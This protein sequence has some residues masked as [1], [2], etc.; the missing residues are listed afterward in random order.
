METTSIRRRALP[1]VLSLVGFY[2]LAFGISAALLGL[3]IAFMHV[4]FLVIP[5]VTMGLFVAIVVV[6]AT[7]QISVD[8]E[9]PPEAVEVGEA[10]HPE[11]FGLIDH[12]ADAMNTDR[13]DVVYLVSD[14]TAAVAET[15]CCSAS[16]VGVASSL[17]AWGSSKC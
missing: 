6:R 3:G 17:S 4:G 14:M 16:S 1:V 2:A 13:P 8:Y 9:P 11:L 5:F 7:F 12:V 10:D 15:P